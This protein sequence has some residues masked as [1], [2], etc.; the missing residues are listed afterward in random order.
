MI[1]CCGEAL[2]DMLPVQTRDGRAAFLPVP[3]GAAFNTAVAL[4]RLGCRAGL[5]AGLSD[6]VFGAR[7]RRVATQGGV[8]LSFCPVSPRPTALAFVHDSASGPVYAFR[9]AGSAGRDLRTDELR[10]RLDGVQA[11]VFGGI[12]LAS[13]PGGAAFET[14]AARC[15]ADAVPVVVDLNIRPAAIS[16][17]HT[18]RERLARLLGLATVIKVSDEDLAWLL[19]GQ[20]ARS[21]GEELARSAGAPL[22]LLTEGARGAAALVAGAWQHAE[23]EKVAVVDTVGA[24]DAFVAGFLAALRDN[25]ALDGLAG[26]VGAETLAKALDFACRVAT[27]TVA[28]AGADPPWREEIS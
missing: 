10:T 24:G 13:D 7:L 18:Y 19:P 9:D 8:D 16:D 26:G 14:L 6:D 21:A 23:A 2:I 4:A 11:A 25:G 20:S 5:V 15:A 1:L 28:R 17:A 22:L 27:R 3:G 12:S